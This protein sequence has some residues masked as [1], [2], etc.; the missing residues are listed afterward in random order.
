MVPHQCFILNL[1]SVLLPS[2]IARE[3]IFVFLSEVCFFKRVLLFIFQQKWK[4]CLSTSVADLGK[5]PATP[6]SSFP[7]QLF[8]K[9]TRC[10]AGAEFSSLPGLMHPSWSLREGPVQS[11]CSPDVPVV[12]VTKTD[13]I[14]SH[15]GALNWNSGHVLQS[16]KTKSGINSLKISG[17]S[18]SIC[19]VTHPFL[20]RTWIRVEGLS[21]MN[22][23]KKNTV[24]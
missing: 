1:P 11:A 8:S 15:R 13:H 6:C 14:L 12:P 3:E 9:H 5:S 16:H 4:H 2:M 10:G 18:Q 21:Q 23:M 19:R 22:Q 7:L 17:K 24:Y 20:T